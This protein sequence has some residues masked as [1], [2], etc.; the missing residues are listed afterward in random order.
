MTP[1]YTNE[2]IIY[3]SLLKF[4]LSDDYEEQKRLYQN[5]I[6]QI[7]DISTISKICEIEKLL[8]QKT[9]LE[10]LYVYQKGVEKSEENNK[11]FDNADLDT[12]CIDE[13][14]LSFLYCNNLIYNNLE[15]ALNSK[16]NQLRDFAKSQIE[17]DTIESLLEIYSDCNYEIL[18]H[19]YFIGAFPN[20]II[21]YDIK[22]NS[23]ILGQKLKK[24]R[25]DAN[26]TQEALGE[27]LNTER[28]NISNYERGN[29][30]PPISIIIMYSKLFN[31]SPLYLLYDT[32]PIDAKKLFR[33]TT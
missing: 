2:N 17:S 6:E 15:K 11:P 16:R 29:N 23:N 30:K 31:V 19:S 26:L 27:L 20:Y 7:K 32:I 24:C 18:K 5:S 13:L 9:N 4:C 1:N 28:S 33:C 25:K 3:N 8:K 14:D 10:I 21:P 22:F 12:F